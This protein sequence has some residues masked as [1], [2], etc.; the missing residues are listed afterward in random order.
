METKGSY[1][2]QATIRPECL[3]V[4]KDWA[5]P[6]ADEVRAALKMAR[7]SGE[8]LS[9]RIGVDSCTVRRWTLEKSQSTMLLGVCYALR[10]DLAKSGCLYRFRSV[11]KNKKLGEVLAMG[12]N[13]SDYKRLSVKEKDEFDKNS[14]QLPDLIEVAYNNLDPLFKMYNDKFYIP[15]GGSLSLQWSTKDSVEAWVEANKF[16]EAPLH[17]VCITYELIKQL[18]A[19]AQAFTR[20]AIHGLNPIFNDILKSKGVVISGS[21]FYPNGVN[22]LVARSLLFDFSINWIISHE[23]AHSLQSHGTVRYG[24]PH[25]KWLAQ[26][27]DTEGNNSCSSEQ[28]EIFHATE[29]A[30]DYQGFRELIMNIIAS[31]RNAFA[32]KKVNEAE[33]T[34]SDVWIIFISIALVLLRFHSFKGEKFDGA[35]KGDHPHPAIRYLI[36]TQSII[37]LLIEDY[38]QD[39]GGFN[40]REEDLVKTLSDT[41]WIAT[42]F[43][44]ERHEKGVEMINFAEL[45]TEPESPEIKNYLTKI[46]TR[47]DAIRPT[48]KGGYDND[49]HLMEFNIFV[50]RITGVPVPY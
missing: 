37:G 36:L 4:R 34:L 27:H 30:A 11:A 20:Y 7:W 50:R 47:W 24:M 23:I 31:K 6:T 3:C 17:E 29:L 49:F 18:G 28:A 13:F 44:A 38:M 26:S 12:I 48:I 5:E 35:I 46:V 21:G 42:L 2:E 8:E 43:W 22:P 32:D 15:Q 19:D 41:F 10:L 33:I 1:G 45:M 25:T 16:S 14:V 40:F 39:I 9:R